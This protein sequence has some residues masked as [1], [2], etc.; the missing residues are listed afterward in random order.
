M[1][2]EL[3][4]KLVAFDT[5]S[6][7]SNLQLV[8]WA[9]DFLERIGARVCVIPDPTG[10]KANLLASFGPDAPGGI[11]LSAHTDTVPVDG[12]VWSSDPFQLVEREGRLHGRGAVDMKGFIACCLAAARE[13]SQALLKRP[14][15]LALTYDE[16]IGCFGASSLAADLAGRL[17]APTVVVVGEPTGMRIADRHRGYLGFR[18]SFHGRAAHSGDPGLG[19]SAIAAASR[20]VSLLLENMP[21]AAGSEST[22]VNV[23]LIS[24]GTHINIVPGLCEVHWE[25][26]PAADADVAELRSRAEAIIHRACSGNLRSETKATVDIPPLR[27][28][29]DHQAIELVE[30]LGGVTPLAELP[31]GTEAGFFQAVGLPAVVCGPGSI[32]QAHQP[33]EW[34]SI[35]QLQDASRFMGRV[36]EWAQRDR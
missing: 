22:T 19:E 26:R 30:K 24:G 3:L 31:F 17:P 33:D 6:R 2:I 35:Q 28:A 21:G 20:F 9:A 11:V 36:A 15:H 5:T 10:A 25:I 1:A 14:I 18:T 7:N 34:I 13:F 16:E 12:Q 4:R 29:V 8:S 23:G 32:E 27:P